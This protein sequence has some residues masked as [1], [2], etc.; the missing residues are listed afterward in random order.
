M[1]AQRWGSNPDWWLSCSTKPSNTDVLSIHPLRQLRRTGVAERI[2]NARRKSVSS[3]TAFIRGRK[4]SPRPP[5]PTNYFSLGHVPKPFIYGQGEGDVHGGSRLFIRW[6]LWV[7][8]SQPRLTP[9]PHCRQRKL[10]P[11][12]P[13]PDPVLPLLLCHSCFSIHFKTAPERISSLCY[14]ICGTSSIFPLLCLQLL[15]IHILGESV[16]VSLISVPRCFRFYQPL[17]RF[18]QHY[19]PDRGKSPAFS[20]KTGLQHLPLKAM[21]SLPCCG[22]WRKDKCLVK[23]LLHYTPQNVFCWYLLYTT[24]KCILWPHKCS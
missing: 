18:V 6:V 19:S 3:L 10:S 2:P 9:H 22:I 5:T 13:C 11:T 23:D 14:D 12:R 8:R 15:N 21:F 7:V 17:G 20:A 1:E 16:F 4:P 24:S